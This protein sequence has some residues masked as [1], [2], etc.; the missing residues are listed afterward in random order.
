MSHGSPH[1][2]SNVPTPAMAASSGHIH[3]A[4]LRRFDKL[5]KPAPAPAQEFPDS[6]HLGVYDVGG[7]WQARAHRW[8]HPRRRIAEARRPA[9]GSAKYLPRVT[10]AEKT[11]V[12]EASPVVGESCESACGDWWQG[13]AIGRRPDDEAVAR[14]GCCADPIS[15][16][17]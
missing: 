9:T 17:L 10:Q 2:T 15:V 14:G 8:T 4:Q 11:T 5:Q 3:P 1:S 16:D 7:Q 6:S 13:A 12:Y